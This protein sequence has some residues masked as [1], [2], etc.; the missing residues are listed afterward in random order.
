MS[1][2]DFSSHLSINKKPYLKSK[3]I[4]HSQNSRQD[5]NEHDWS[6]LEHESNKIEGPIK[7]TKKHNSYDNK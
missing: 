2:G 6:W 5:L 7:M 3:D 4:S 1:A